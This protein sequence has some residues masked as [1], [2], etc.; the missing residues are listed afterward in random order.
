MNRDIFLEFRNTILGSLSAHGVSYKLFGGAVICLIND[1]RETQDLD[2]AIKAELETTE[3]F[4][5]A[6]A[7]C[8][9][10]DREYI[11]MQIYGEN[12]S[13]G[14]NMYSTCHLATKNPRWKGLHIDLCFDLGE[15]NYEKNISA[16]SLKQV[17][18]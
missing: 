7:S 12:A 14:E 10:A 17:N 11:S 2:I 18:L 5:D 4:I 9:Y 3:K 1:E 16:L 8:G 15:H 6:L 13:P